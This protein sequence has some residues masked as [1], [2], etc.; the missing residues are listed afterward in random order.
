MSVD[1]VI[2]NNFVQ[3]EINCR[4]LL[5]HYTSNTLIK[6]SATTQ[7]RIPIFTISI[8]IF[9]IICQYQ[10]TNNKLYVLMHDEQKKKSVT[11]L[12]EAVNF[13]KKVPNNLYKKN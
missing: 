5:Y 6:L 7:K 3:H 2:E 12:I 13:L 9:F 8:F 11:F 4:S 1:S 10:T